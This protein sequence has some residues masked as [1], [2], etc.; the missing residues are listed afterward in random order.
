[1]YL[2]TSQPCYFCNISKDKILEHNWHVTH[3][4]DIPQNYTFQ[5]LNSTPNG[6]DLK[7]PTS[8]WMIFVG[9]NLLRLV[10]W[11]AISVGSSESITVSLFLFRTRLC[12]AKKK[13]PP[14]GIAAIQQDDKLIIP[15]RKKIQKTTM[16]AKTGKRVTSWSSFPSLYLTATWLRDFS[17]SEVVGGETAPKK[18]G[19]VSRDILLQWA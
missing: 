16:N 3:G 10:S 4:L 19:D 13:F 11:T 6:G 2:G 1:M 18:K 9:Q 14:S 8:F 17:S 5:I 15:T 12:H 7:W